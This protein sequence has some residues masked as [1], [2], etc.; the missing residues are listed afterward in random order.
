MDADR[1]GPDLPAKRFLYRSS[2]GKPRVSIGGNTFMF[3]VSFE[4][5]SY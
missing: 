1:S 3:R 5:I 2:T 4:K